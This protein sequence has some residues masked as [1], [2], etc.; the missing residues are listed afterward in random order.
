MISV[1]V[2]DI[3]RSVVKSKEVRASA[4]QWKV[5]NAIISC[6]TAALGGHLYRCSECDHSEPRYNSC[7][8]RHC[9]KCQGADIAKWLKAR[10]AELLPVSYFHTVFTVPHELNPLFLQ[11]KALLFEVL[12]KAVAETIKEATLSRYGGEAGFF[13]VMHSWGQKLDFLPHIHCVIPAVVLKKD[14]TISKSPNNYFIPDRIL[15]KLF[16]AIF[17]KHLERVQAKLSFY[18]QSEYLSDPTELQ[19][20]KRRSVTK[21]WVVYS[22]KPFAG[23][24]AVLKYLSRYTHRVAVSNSRIKEL[25]N[26]QVSFSYKDYSCGSK[27]KLLTLSA[28]EFSRR[29]LLHTIPHR[30]VRIRHFGF[31]ANAS[32]YKN[33]CQ[34]RSL[35]TSTSLQV[36]TADVAI[37]CPKCSNGQLLKTSAFNPI[38][39]LTLITTTPRHIIPHRAQLLPYALGARRLMLN[40]G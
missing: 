2:A 8:N 14:G 4:E 21:D 37:R 33:L 6:R 31:L 22:K 39:H 17:M 15:S 13:A 18:G 24:E 5:I 16:R 32:K 30:F 34:I 38:R 20:L 35:L 23:A 3:L 36:T 29:F 1:G 26:G 10:S 11:N 12:F 9:P 19:K 40:T 7:R 28:T 27:K 25:S